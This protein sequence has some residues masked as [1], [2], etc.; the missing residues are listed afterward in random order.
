MSF[1]RDEL[2]HCLHSAVAASTLAGDVVMNHYGPSVQV[3]SKGRTDS[4]EGD[5]VT[6]A[7]REAQSVVIDWLSGVYSDRI[8]L[9]SEEDGLDR[10][11]SRFSKEAFWCVDPLDGTFQF[12]RRNNSFSVNIGL[13]SAEGEA[14]LG[15]VY[16]PALRTLI[17][18]IP[19][20]G[21]WVQDVPVDL[22]ASARGDVHVVF[23]YRDA[24]P[25]ARNQ[26][27]NRIFQSLERMPAVSGVKPVPA[28]SA[29][30]HIRYMQKWSPWVVLT[31]PSP[32]GGASLWDVAA[33]SA[34]VQ[35]AGGWVGNLDGEPLDLNPPDTTFIQQKGLLFCS[36]AE[37]ADVVVNAFHQET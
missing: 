19:G 21:A 31:Y 16:A 28:E 7:D 5:V 15:V 1:T 13:V 35:A 12:L 24:L 11:L 3:G 33:Q 9:L 6:R 23:H 25:V 14:L 18:G 20:V 34:V 17:H 2:R 30:M 37:L 36:H 10:D 29:P 22:G 26:T 32:E 27:L 8:G 4:E